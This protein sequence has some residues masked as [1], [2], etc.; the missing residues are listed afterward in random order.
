MLVRTSHFAMSTESPGETISC[1]DFSSELKIDCDRNPGS[2]NCSMKTTM[3]RCC[4]FGVSTTGVV[5]VVFES[6]TTDFGSGAYAAKLLIDCGLPSSKTSKSSL[7]RPCTRWPRLSV[8]MTSRF[9]IETSIVSPARAIGLIAAAGSA[10]D[11]ANSVAASHRFLISSLLHRGQIDAREAAVVR[12][13]IV[14]G[15]R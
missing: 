13:L 11:I 10:N 5:S 8:T 12:D 14:H 3:V 9:T 1:S 4:R 15:H 6:V 7:V 2:L